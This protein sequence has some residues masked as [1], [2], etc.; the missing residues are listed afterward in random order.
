MTKTFAFAYASYRSWMSVVKLLTLVP[1]KAEVLELQTGTDFLWLLNREIT[2]L[3]QLK[4]SGIELEDSDRRL[5]QRDEKDIRGY[6]K[7]GYVGSN[8]TDEAT[9]RRLIR[10]EGRN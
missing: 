1:W 7:S 6:H 5:S 3:Q 2:S 8:P 9:Q 4:I 10:G